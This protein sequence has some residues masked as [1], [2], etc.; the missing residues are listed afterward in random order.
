MSLCV[1]F[2]LQAAKLDAV[3]EPWAYE[4]LAGE[5]AARNYLLTHP[6]MAK[7]VIAFAQVGAWHW[8]SPMRRCAWGGWV[9]THDSCCQSFGHVRWFV[10]F[11]VHDVAL[12]MSLGY[13]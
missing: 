10:F 9:G 4:P 6:R 2:C 13:L 12:A 8:Q 3:L 1:C 7:H 11:L 5:A